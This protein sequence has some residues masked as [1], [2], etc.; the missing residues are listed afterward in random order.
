MIEMPKSMASNKTNK[1]FCISLFKKLSEF[2]YSGTYG[3][4]ILD[5]SLQDG[6]IQNITIKHYDKKDLIKLDKSE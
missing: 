2:F 6:V 1:D 5:V 3:H 4:V